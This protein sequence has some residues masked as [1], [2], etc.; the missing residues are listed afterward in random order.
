[1]GLSGACVTGLIWG[2][3][4]SRMIKNDK[5]QYSKLPSSFQRFITYLPIRLFM[6]FT[7]MTVVRAMPPKLKLQSLIC[8]ELHFVCFPSNTLIAAFTIAMSCSRRR[9]C[10]MAKTY[11]FWKK[12]KQK[13]QNW[14]ISKILNG[15]SDVL[16]MKAIP[17]PSGYLSECARKMMK[18]NAVIFVFSSVE[19][20]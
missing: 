13:H 4:A 14:V 2:A 10:L 15:F 12:L 6:V 18:N 8:H 17:L 9:A 3:R 7:A 5:S 19:P 1:M 11:S 16:K 20:F